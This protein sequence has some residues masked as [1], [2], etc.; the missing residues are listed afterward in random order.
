[1]IIVDN[2]AASRNGDIL[3]SRFQAQLDTVSALINYKNNDNME[4]SIGLMTMGG[5]S[6]QVLVTPTNDTSHLYSV[7]N[8]I[9]VSGIPKFG[10]ALQ[11][12]QLA[13]KHRINKHQKERIIVF[14]ADT[15]NEAESDVIELCRK[16]RRNNTQIDIVNISSPNNVAVMKN[17]IDTVNVED[18]SCFVDYGPANTESLVDVVKKSAIMYNNANMG[19]GGM[20][21]FQANNDEYDDELQ[22]VLRMSLEE[23]RKRQEELKKKEEGQNQEDGDAEQQQLL[24]EANDIVDKEDKQ[25]EN[26]HLKDPE[27]IQEI[28]EELKED[29]KKDQDKDDTKQ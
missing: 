8:K 2:S 9:K 15:V 4:T 14:T 5:D 22:A 1:M 25:E 29:D 12:A 27:F 28:L 23:E 16:M 11:I 17:I 6:V 19:G 18:G 20:G 24:Q 21:D 26:E 13:L 3:P 7:Y 10:K